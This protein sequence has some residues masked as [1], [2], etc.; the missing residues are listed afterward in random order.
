MATAFR[1]KAGASIH[2]ILIV[3]GENMS[4][5]IFCKIIEGE[6]PSKKIYEDKDILAFHDI[7]PAAP[8]HFMIIPKL[9]IASLMEA[10]ADHQAI[11]GKLLTMAAPL[12]KELGS[13]E[14]FRTIINTGKIGRQEVYHLHMHVLGG[15][16]PLGAMI[17]RT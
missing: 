7:Y 1:G 9:H 10:N 17:S 8:V 6:I 15:P 14:G 3:P 16:T 12:A 4:D 11:L 2:G 13:K 5:C